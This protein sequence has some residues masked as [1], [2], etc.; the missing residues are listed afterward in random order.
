MVPGRKADRIPK[1]PYRRVGDLGDERGRYGGP[2]GDTRVAF[3]PQATRRLEKTH[4]TS[5]GSVYAHS[6]TLW[7]TPAYSVCRGRPPAFRSAAMRSRDTA[8]G[9]VLSAAP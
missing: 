7:P 1:R 2:A 6:Q 4:R 9:T 3:R 5:A 8:R